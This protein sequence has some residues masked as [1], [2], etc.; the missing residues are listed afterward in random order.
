MTQITQPCVTRHFTK[1]HSYIYDTI[2][3]Y[4]HALNDA[5]NIALCD[6][7]YY[8]GPFIYRLSGLEVYKYTCLCFSTYKL[9]DIYIYIYIYMFSTVYRVTQKRFLCTYTSMWAPVVARHISKR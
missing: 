6:T 9:Y 3:L 2:R 8:K 7:S 4:A 1:D 5:D